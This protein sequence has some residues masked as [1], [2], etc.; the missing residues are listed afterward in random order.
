MSANPL[1][2]QYLA[3]IDDERRKAGLAPE[4]IDASVDNCC[5]HLRA[6]LPNVDPATLGEVLLHAMALHGTVRTAY[7]DRGFDGRTASKI[8]VN[9]ISLTGE[10]LYTNATTPPDGTAT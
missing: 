2:D 10:R 7:A 3:H 4:D 5:A 9:L 8:A 1:T 6:A